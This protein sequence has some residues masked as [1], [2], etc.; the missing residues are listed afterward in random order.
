[1]KLPQEYKEN[2]NQEH[3]AEIKLFTAQ[4]VFL[5][6]QNLSIHQA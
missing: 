6:Q 3:L 4:K 2:L 5:S 1:M